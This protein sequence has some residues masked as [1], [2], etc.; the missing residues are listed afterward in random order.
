M[1]AAPAA[2]A[3]SAF[4]QLMDR[5]RAAPGLLFMVIAMTLLGEWASR[6]LRGN[7]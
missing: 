4:D 7:R 2:R 1:T 3:L 5:L 6:R